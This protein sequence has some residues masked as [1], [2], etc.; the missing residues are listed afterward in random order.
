MNRATTFE[1]TWRHVELG[2]AVADVVAGVSADLAADLQTAHALR[3]LGRSIE[4]PAIGAAWAH[5][6]DKLDV[7]APIHHRTT[8]SPARLARAFLAVAAAFTLLVAVSLRAGPGSVLYGLRRG[9]EQVA[10]ALSPS[11]GSLHLR[12][13]G[14]RLDDLLGSLSRGDYGRAPAVAGSLA[15]ERTAAATDGADVSGL[16]ALIRVEVPAALAAAPPEVIRAVDDALSDPLGRGDDQRNGAGSR[17]SG[18]HGGGD[19]GGR[20]D[21]GAATHGRPSD[22]SGGSGSGDGTQGSTTT[23]SGDGSNGSGPQGDR[24][25]SGD[26]SGGSGQEGDQGG[27]GDGTQGSGAQT[28][29][30]DSSHQD[31]SPRQSDSQ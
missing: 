20:G 1:E 31:V 4:A 26:G 21:P 7:A 9:A 24:G 12:L 14:A 22:G 3:E 15:S 16:D 19:P 2:W 29:S 28:G 13:A 23:G 11:D 10:V 8:R 6:E 27:S 17:P 18:R 25:G 30:G 5:L